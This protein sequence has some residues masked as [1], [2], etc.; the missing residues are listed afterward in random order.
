[1]KT[2][3]LLTLLTIFIGFSSC[4]NDDDDDPVILR[5]ESESV[6]NLYA[7]Q[8][9]GF[10]Q[11][12]NPL[13]ITGEFTKFD[14]SSGTTTTSTTDWDIAFRGTNII[15]NG[16]TSFGA[17]DEPERTGNAAAYM[18][19]STMA[20][21]LEVDVQL[22]QQ[23]SATGYVLSNWYDYN[24]V[25]HIIT[26]TAGKILVIRTRDGKY[27]KVEIL[28]YYKDNPA[29]ITTEIATNDARYYTFNYVNQPNEGVTTFE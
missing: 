29:E 19:N 23:D 11:M 16:G 24:P 1:M 10:D 20:N 4:S 25:N 13:P 15:I 12:G 8:E 7:P 3:K 14:F 27:A 5:V 17:T 21:V 28:S 9:G 22:L 26:P 6:S 2:I 18:E